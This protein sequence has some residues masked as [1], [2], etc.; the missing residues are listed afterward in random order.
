MRA[1]GATPL[2]KT[3]SACV[4][5]SPIDVTLSAVEYQMDGEGSRMPGHLSAWTLG[6][7]WKSAIG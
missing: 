7:N 3:A 5:N 6:R 1:S 4:S 2:R